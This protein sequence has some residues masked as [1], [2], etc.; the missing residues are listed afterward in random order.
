LK[1]NPDACCYRGGSSPDSIDTE[2]TEVASVRDTT[3]MVFWR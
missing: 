1:I 3:G 2:E